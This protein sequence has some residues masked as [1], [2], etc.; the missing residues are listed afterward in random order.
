[1]SKSRY[2]NAQ[3]ACGLR[4]F[5]LYGNYTARPVQTGDAPCFYSVMGALLR[6]SHQ[7]VSLGALFRT[8]LLCTSC[9]VKE[10]IKRRHSQPPLGRLCERITADRPI[11]CITT[12]NTTSLYISDGLQA[13]TAATAMSNNANSLIR[14]YSGVWFPTAQ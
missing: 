14:R 10:G 7:C 6:G 11:I 9:R 3:T 4:A 8:H 12:L 5:G 1:M 2:E 13:T